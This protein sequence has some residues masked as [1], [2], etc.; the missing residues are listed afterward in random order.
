MFAVVSDEEW[1][2]VAGL[3]VDLL[4]TILAV[5]AAVAIV[6]AMRVV[7]ILL[8]AALMVLPVGSAQLIARSFRGTLA[9]SV[10]V[11]VGSVFVGLAASRIWG[12]AP[13]GTIVI[14]AA[15][16]FAVVSMATSRRSPDRAMR[17]VAL[18]REAAVPSRIPGSADAA[19]RDQEFLGDSHS[20]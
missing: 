7:G 19:G 15:L 2:R 9:W 12:L 3:P 5:M 11:G 16:V 14:V 4:N 13:G 8:I 6:A 10:A 17:S 20:H 18:R 1:A